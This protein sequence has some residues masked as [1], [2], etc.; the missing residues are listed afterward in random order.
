MSLRAYRSGLE[1]D[2]HLHL[3]SRGPVA[4]AIKQPR[5]SLATVTSFCI[6]LTQMLYV[7]PMGMAGNGLDNGR[8]GSKVG[9]ARVVLL[10]VLGMMGLPRHH[11]DVSVGQSLS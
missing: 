10:P 1:V 2:R 8:F 3:T 9:V 11:D 4:D 7:E 6:H 5:I